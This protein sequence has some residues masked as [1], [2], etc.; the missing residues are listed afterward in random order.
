TGGAG[1]APVRGSARDCVAVADRRTSCGRGEAR[2]SRAFAFGLSGDITRDREPPAHG[3]L[4]DREPPAHGGSFRYCQPRPRFIVHELQIATNK[5]LLFL[6][7]HPNGFGFPA[8]PAFS[9][10]L[11]I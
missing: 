4:R 11:N 2:G 10:N 8:G 3:G 1:H 5:T 6:P 7:P 9:Q